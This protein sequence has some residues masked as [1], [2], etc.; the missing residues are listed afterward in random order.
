MVWHPTS[1]RESDIGPHPHSRS[2]SVSTQYSYKQC[3][4]HEQTSLP[5]G[6]T[7]THGCTPFAMVVFVI[8]ILIFLSCFCFLSDLLLVSWWQ[9]LPYSYPCSS[10]HKFHLCTTSDNYLFL[11]TSFCTVHSSVQSIDCRCT[12][13]I[14]IFILGPSTNLKGCWG[15]FVLS[16][17]TMWETTVILTHWLSL[18]PVYASPMVSSV[19]WWHLHPFLAP[20]AC[21][22]SCWASFSAT[23]LIRFMLNLF[24]H[25][26]TDHVVHPLFLARSVNCKDIPCLWI[27][28]LF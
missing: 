28:T 20:H 17:H 3:F 11:W 5:T 10:H 12:L 8:F 4:M 2:T 7:A 27:F 1:S 22:G 25:L 16:F 6:L 23:H 24:H 13:R 14:W 21:K 9:T 19:L 26:D 15:L 18:K